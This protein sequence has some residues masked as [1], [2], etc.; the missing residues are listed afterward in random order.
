MKQIIAVITLT[1]I[2]IGIAIYVNNYLTLSANEI[3]NHI[4]NVELYAKKDDWEDAVKELKVSK[5][6][7]DNVKEKWSMLIDHFEIDN[8]ESSLSKVSGFVTT[9]NLNDLLAESSNLRLM[10]DHIPEKDIL[11]MENIL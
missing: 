3:S 2:F 6:K 4:K 8:I 5:E 10:V 11:S 7:W 1:I 9:K